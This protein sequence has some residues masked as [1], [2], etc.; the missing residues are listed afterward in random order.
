MHKPATNIHVI[1]KLFVNHEG[2][3]SGKAEV[4][5]SGYGSNVRTKMYKE[6][7][8]K[9][10]YI[11]GD[12]AEFNIDSIAVDNVGKDELPLKQIFHFSGKLKSSTDYY[13]LPYNIFMGV[14]ENLFIAE[15]RQSAIDFGYMQSFTV[16][17]FMNIDSSF[18]IEELPKSIRMILPDT[19]ISLVRLLQK[20]DGLIN[21]QVSLNLKRERYEADEYPDL[22]MIYKKIFALLSENIALKKKS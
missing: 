6:G 12:L 9:K 3:I 8:L 7:L 18:D 1:C 20:N 16:R 19:S 22:Q 21:F 10:A 17:G 2:I 5:S 11:K 14:S 15:K 4:E 13:F